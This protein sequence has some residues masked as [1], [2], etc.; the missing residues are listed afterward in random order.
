[1]QSGFLASFLGFVVLLPIPKQARRGVVVRHPI[2]VFVRGWFLLLAVGAAVGVRVELLDEPAVSLRAM[3][4]LS[5]VLRA[6]LNAV[7]ILHQTDVLRH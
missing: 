1:M 3:L 2:S 7:F 5:V 4:S 6:F